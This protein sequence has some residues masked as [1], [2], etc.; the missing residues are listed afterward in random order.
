MNIFKSRIKTKTNAGIRLKEH[1]INVI[2]FI[3]YQSTLP[4]KDE[5]RRGKKDKG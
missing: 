3:H 2:I 4:T 5:S 1:N